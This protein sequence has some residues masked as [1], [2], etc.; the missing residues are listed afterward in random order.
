MSN[1]QTTISVGS[2]AF[3]RALKHGVELWH[4]GSTPKFR[5]DQRD[6]RDGFTR[7][8]N[9]RVEGKLAEEAFATFLSMHYGLDAGI[10]YDIYGDIETTDD[11]D[12]KYIRGDDGEEYP[13]SAH[14]DVKKTKTYNKWLAIRK[15]I[16][17][18]HPD[19]APFILTKLSLADD[20]V[21][22]LW[23]DNES[24]EEMMEDPMFEARLQSFAEN[25]FPL[26]VEIVGSAYKDEF[27][28]HFNK[29]DRLYHPDSGN[30]IGGPLRR[31]NMGIPCQ[32]LIDNAERWDR[33]VDEITE[34]I[35]VEYDHLS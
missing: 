30:H 22:D 23:E 4:D 35:P 8:C 27:T 15:S 31:E 2:D 3:V 5:L 19:D 28:D 21:L 6:D 12:L 26:D 13:P 25:H 11:G 17:D 18:S 33:I 7:Y 32:D 20:L 1:I 34:D 10:D 9:A 24:W 29:G 16:F 14:L